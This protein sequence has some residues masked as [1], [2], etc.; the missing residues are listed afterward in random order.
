MTISISSH[1]DCIISRWVTFYKFF[2]IFMYFLSEF[3]VKIVQVHTL[4]ANQHTF[5]LVL[6]IR[7][8]NSQSRLMH[9]RG[10]EDLCFRCVDRLANGTR[11]FHEPEFL[12]VL[13]F[14]L[15]THNVFAWINRTNISFYL[16]PTWTWTWT[17]F[18]L[19]CFSFLF[20]LLLIFMQSL[21]WYVDTF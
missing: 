11:M 1:S 2:V 6:S 21:T 16:Q 4:H 19:P 20:S 8:W 13:F 17:V 9:G 14:L 10:E 18:L 3:E 15:L 5:G 7:E 12:I